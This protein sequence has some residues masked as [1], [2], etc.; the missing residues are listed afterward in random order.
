MDLLTYKEVE[1]RPE[2]QRNQSFGHRAWVWL[3]TLSPTVV[4]IMVA[5]S[6]G[7]GMVAVQVSQL[8][9]LVV[10]AIFWGLTVVA[11][12]GVLARWMT[13]GQGRHRMAA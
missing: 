11:M 9:V 7:L 6:V 8:W 10:L 5:L 12:G 2:A 4:T 13:P 1:S 3:L